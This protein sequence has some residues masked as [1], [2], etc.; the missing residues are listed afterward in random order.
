MVS[1]GREIKAGLFPNTKNWF[2]FF[3]FF[4]WSSLERTQAQKWKRAIP[5]TGSKQILKDV[6]TPIYSTSVFIHTLRV[7]PPCLEPHQSHART[8]TNHHF[9]Y[10]AYQA[11]LFFQLTCLIVCLWPLSSCSFFRCEWV[12]SVC[13]G[14][15]NTM[16][17]WRT[18]EKGVSQ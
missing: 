5:S 18:S 14:S 2:W 6:N 8:H 7:M 16:F 11:C 12:H 17:G 10:T 13:H 4:W 1:K 3:F 9:L 15:K